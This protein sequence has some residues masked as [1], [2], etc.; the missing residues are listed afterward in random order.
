MS[1]LGGLLG[2]GPQ[3]PF[4]MTFNFRV[5]DNKLP[6]EL[7]GG[8]FRFPLSFKLGRQCTYLSCG[9]YSSIGYLG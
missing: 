7:T 1:N 3:Y 9:R 5:A 6:V 2:K 8:V 4:F